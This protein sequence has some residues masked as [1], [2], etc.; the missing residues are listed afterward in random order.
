MPEESIHFEA[1]EREK[2]FL[3]ELKHA[4]MSLED[5][6][7][8]QNTDVKELRALWEKDAKEALEIDALLKL[9]GKDKNVEV[10]EE[11]LEEEI[12]KMKETQKGPDYIYE[13]AMWRNNVK[14]VML[15]QKAYKELISEVLKD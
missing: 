7:K 5:F 10:S 1:R 2:S 14:N 15:K 8:M 4:N 12:K 11:E 3:H 13:D 6:C 9:Y